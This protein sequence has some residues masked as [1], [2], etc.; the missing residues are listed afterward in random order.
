MKPEMLSLDECI[1]EPG[2]Y[3]DPEEGVIIRVSK[4]P[5]LLQH[6]EEL[7]VGKKGGEKTTV[8][9]KISNDPALN[10]EEVEGI[11]RARKL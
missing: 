11:I 1:R 6:S 7:A 4:V 2:I 9:M 8:C 10:D 5:P 3:Y